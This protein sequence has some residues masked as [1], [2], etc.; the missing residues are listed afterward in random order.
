MIE[1]EVQF[2]III[3]TI[4]FSMF[5]TNLYTCI[6]ILLRKSKV[7]RSLIELCFFALTSV[8]YYLLIYRINKG[9]LSVYIPVCL[10]F[11]WYL[12]MK[13]YDK[14]FSCFYKYIFSKIH[15]II[16]LQRSKWHKLWKELMTKKTKEVKST[17]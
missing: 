3:S 13:F 4:V 10:L 14:Y 17:E 8:L 1:L 2:Q 9:I 6:N 7:F 16:D 11:G 15:S 5:F 12:H